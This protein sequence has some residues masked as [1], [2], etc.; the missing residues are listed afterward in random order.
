[1]VSRSALPRLADGGLENL[2]VALKRKNP[3][4]VAF[5]LEQHLVSLLLCEAGPSTRESIRPPATKVTL[6]R[7]GIWFRASDSWSRACGMYR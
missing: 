3:A 4:E 1:M 2:K 7:I 5:G 6:A